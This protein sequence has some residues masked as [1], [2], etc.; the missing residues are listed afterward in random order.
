MAVWEITEMQVAQGREDEFVHTFQSHLSIV[1]NAEGALDCKLLRGVDK[2]G[3]FLLLIEWQ[4]V[5]HHTEVFTKSEGF[6]TL[7]TAVAPFLTAPPAVFHGA[8]VLDGI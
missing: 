6:T 7:S 8:I 1:K 2:E 5:E 4:S 3:A